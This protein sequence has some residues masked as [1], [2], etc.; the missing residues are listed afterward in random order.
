MTPPPVPPPFAETLLRLSVRDAEWRDAVIG[1]LRE[2]LAVVA[3]ARGA[4]AATR[5]YWRQALPLA[6]RFAVSRL[7]PSLRPVRRRPSVADIESTSL[8]GAGWSKELRHA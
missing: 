4:S 5:W 7:V 2:E 8:L 6:L 1:D 3:A